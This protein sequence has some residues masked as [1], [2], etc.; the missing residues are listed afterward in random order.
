MRLGLTVFVFV[1]L[2]SILST[3]A[4]QTASRAGYEE[5]LEKGKEH[6]REQTSGVASNGGP[7]GGWRRKRNVKGKFFFLGKKDKQAATH[8]IQ[9]LLYNYSLQKS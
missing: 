2:V 6:R 7:I 8:H 1:T 5:V 4:Q 9:E 3:T